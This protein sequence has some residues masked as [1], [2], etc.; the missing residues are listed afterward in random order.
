MSKK[1]TLFVLQEYK[2]ALLQCYGRYLQQF[3]CVNLDDLMHDVHRFKSTFFP[4]GFRDKN[5]AL[6]V[7]SFFFFYPL[8]T[9]TDS[10]QVAYFILHKCTSY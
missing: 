3:V 5:A 4:N 6:T 10:K 9:F 7:G 8:K 1:N 2:L